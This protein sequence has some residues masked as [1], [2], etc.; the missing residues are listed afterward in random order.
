M[1]APLRA[2]RRPTPAGL[3]RFYVRPAFREMAAL[4]A[5][6]ALACAA[7]RAGAQTTEAARD[8]AARVPLVARDGSWKR[9]AAGFATSIAAHEAGHIAASLLQGGHPAFGL[10]HGRPTVYS[11]FDERL[12]PRKQFMFSSA[13]LDVQDLLDEAILDVPHDR[14]GTFERGILAGGLATTAFYLTIGRTGSVSDVAFMERTSTLG[15]GQ[16]ALI[17]G[18]V[19]ALHLVRIERDGRYGQFFVRPDARAGLRV[20]MD[21]R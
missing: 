1:S 2:R 15:Y 3:L 18:G 8:S 5:G 11:G 21:W 17:Y 6:T 19:A 20:G 16:I 9:F 12:H 13:G 10:D 4:A 14:G 7:P